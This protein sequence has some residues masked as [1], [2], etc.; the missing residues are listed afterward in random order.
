LQLFD[1]LTVA[2]LAIIAMCT[3]TFAH[4]ALGHGSACLTLGGHITLLTS[5]L[6]RCD[7]RSG[8]ID[9][10]GPAAS[11]LIGALALGVRA[12]L[13]HGFAK[14]RLTLIF[15][16]AFSFFWEGGYLMRAMILRD[17]DL[18]FFA[19]FLLG[20]VTPWMQAVGIAIGLGLYLLGVRITT[21]GLLTL[22]ATGEARAVARTAW[23][24]AT[25]AA[26]AATLLYHRAP[27]WPDL[28]DAVLEIGLAS[29]ALLIIPRGKTRMPRMPALIARSYTAIALAALVFVVFAMTLGRG[30]GA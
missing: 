3:V 20:A 27:L 28:R 30:V 16:T 11:L 17:G 18:Y 22:F 21:Q 25:L 10:A 26:F 29:I 1:R 9:Q 2:A 4:E 23:I 13:P 8:W 6:F 15:I 12:L 19:Q 5:S 14:T 24:A 7:L